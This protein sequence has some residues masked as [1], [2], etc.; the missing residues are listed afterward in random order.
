MYGRTLLL[1]AV[2][3]PELVVLPTTLLVALTRTVP[4][5]NAAVDQLVE[6]AGD[7]YARQNYPLTGEYWAPSGFGDLYN[8]VK[9]SFPQVI[10]SWGLLTGWALLD[11]VSGQCVNTGALMEPMATTPGMVP[12]VDPGALTLG[13]GD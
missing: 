2:F 8:T 3:T 10:A 11:T 12:Y 4:P 1:R 9:V 6:P 5:A 7:G 13:I